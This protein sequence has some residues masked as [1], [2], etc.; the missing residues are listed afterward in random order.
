MTYSVKEVFYTLQGEGRHAGSPAVFIRFAGC[1]LWNGQESGRQKGSLKAKCPLWCDT[2]FAKGTKME[3][4]DVI[5]SVRGVIPDDILKAARDRSY[6]PLFVFTGGEP[7][8]QLDSSLISLMREEFNC[9][10]SVETNGTIPRGGLDLDW[11]CVSPKV[12]PDKIAMTTGDEM[13]VV[14]PSYDPL[15]YYEKFKGSFSHFWL[16]A[17]AETHEVGRSLIVKDNLKQAADYCMKNP[18]WRLTLQS[19]KIIG[20]D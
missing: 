14:Y 19:H 3:A 15:P 7:L 12:A 4:G 6:A 9:I 5:E 11:V 17:E 18:P 16:S 8:L 10:V 1:N 20:I 2:D 13:K